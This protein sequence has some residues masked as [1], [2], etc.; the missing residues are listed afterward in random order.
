MTLFVFWRLSF[1]GLVSLG[2]W[3][4][5]WG[6]GTKYICVLS[7]VSTNLWPLFKTD[8][9]AS[10]PRVLF[11]SFW[12][13]A[14]RRSKL[15]SRRLM[16]IIALWSGI[17]KTNTQVLAIGRSY[18][19][20]RSSVQFKKRLLNGTRY[21]PISRWTFSHLRRISSIW[22]HYNSKRFSS[23]K[24]QHRFLPMIP[25]KLPRM[26]T[27]KT[28]RKMTDPEWCD[29]WH[30]RRKRHRMYWSPLSRSTLAKNTAKTLKKPT[31]PRLR[32]WL[33]KQLCQSMRLV[34]RGLLPRMRLSHKKK[35]V[36]S[37]WLFLPAMLA[38]RINLP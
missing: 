20:M 13:A 4:T 23:T 21:L 24:M 7:N 3:T 11:P 9:K 35:Y 12:R 27:T 2:R 37:T 31:C 22:Q 26:L 17:Y 30:F 15:W 36:I 5:I 32:R 28:T 14:R 16:K 1:H 6:W 34:E 29:A 19:W 10:T 18:R 38:F 25:L 33:R 8:W